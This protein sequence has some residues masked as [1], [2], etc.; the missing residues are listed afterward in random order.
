MERAEDKIQCPCITGIRYSTPV[1]VGAGLT[2]APTSLLLSTGIL[3]VGLD[4]AGK[5][6][7]Y[8]C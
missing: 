7:E 4:A 5:T 1:K 6:S 8:L 2:F 3:M